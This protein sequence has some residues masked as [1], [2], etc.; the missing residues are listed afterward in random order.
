MTTNKQQ[1][2]KVDD[3]TV[4][5]KKKETQKFERGENICKMYVLCNTICISANTKK[6]GKKTRCDKV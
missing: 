6:H 4:D 1:R 3:D 5:E 2:V